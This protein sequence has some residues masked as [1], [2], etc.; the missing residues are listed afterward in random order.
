M[1]GGNGRYIA[2]VVAE[3]AIYGAGNV[4]MKVAYEGITPLWCMA[5]RF[6]I[7]LAV[8]MVVAGPRVLRSLRQARV[9]AWLPSGAAMAGTYLACSLAVDLTTATSAGFFVSLPMMFAPLFALVLAGERYGKSTVLL[10]VVAVAGLYLL[11]CGE[12]GARF[13]AGELL[14]LVSSASF[15][16][17]LVLTR[18]GAREVDPLALAAA[19]MAV[20][21]AASLAAA[22]ATEPLPVLAEMPAH[23]TAAILL[24]ACVGTCLPMALQNVAL[25]RVPPTIVSAILCSE[26]VF[27]AA[28]SA[29]VLG[30][31]LG[32][33]GMLGAAVVVAATVAASLQGSEGTVHLRRRAGR[34]A[35]R[36]R[37]RVAASLRT[38]V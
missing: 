23:S 10:Q 8:L 32:G 25:V 36:M 24:L 37:R 1:L 13:G 29:A 18:N 17:M 34:G 14:G 38:L 19:Q 7:A 35:L 6:G 9:S 5:L 16:L 33:A 4:V 21:F 27:T 12:G 26:P 20:T 22:A 28:V 3:A 11:C 31:T 15:A 30:E 2:L